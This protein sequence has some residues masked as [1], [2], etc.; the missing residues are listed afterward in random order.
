MPYYIGDVIKSK[1]R[2]IARTPEEFKKSGIDVILRTSVE[3]IDTAKGIVNISTG[4][5]LPY[6]D[7]VIATGAEAVSPEIPGLDLEGVFHFHNLA[8]ALKLKSYLDK[9]KC[10]KA[11]IIGGGVIG[12]QIAEAFR[13][14]HM[15]V[16]ILHI[17][18]APGANYESK[19][20][21]YVLEEIRNHQVEFLSETVTQSIEPGP[22]FRLLV[23]TSKGDFNADVVLIAI[24][25]KRN[26][27]LAESVGLKMGETG[28]IQV[29]FSQ[30]TSWENIYAAGDCCE[31]FHRVSRRWAYLPLGDVA[32][33]QG[34]TAGRNIGG[35]PGIFPGVVGSRS[36]KVFGLEIAVTGLNEAEAVKSGFA[37][38]S[39][40]MWGSPVSRSLSRGEKLGLNMIADKST[41]K[42][43]GAQCVGVGGAVKR[44]DTLAAALWNEMDIEEIGYLDLAYSPAFGGG[45]DPIHI[46]AQNL[47]RKL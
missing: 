46:A 20:V 44:I 33:K 38:V 5:D 8:D 42:L 13:N 31:V 29:N 30:K 1:R 15:E 19:L 7:L 3:E 47:A 12:M 32:N 28:A 27:S 6:D 24:G 23:K 26:I 21:Q 37:P 9:N 10:R 43:L 11:V 25:A 40:F 16:N 17:R 35:C 22:G 34:R 41:G 4:Q 2:L 45:W 36:L 18:P 14:L 39:F